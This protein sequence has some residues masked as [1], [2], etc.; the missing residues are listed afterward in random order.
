MKLIS[1]L[2]C[3][4]VACSVN[5]F[6]QSFIHTVESAARNK[7]STGDCSLDCISAATIPLMNSK[8]VQDH[9]SVH[10]HHPLTVCQW[11]TPGLVKD[12]C[13]MKSEANKCIQN[14]PN[15]KTKTLMNIA[16]EGFFMCD[17][18]FKNFP[19]L[20]PCINKTC[21]EVDYFCAAKCQRNRLSNADKLIQLLQEEGR[22]S[23]I[24]EQTPMVIYAETCSYLNC[25]DNCS[26][27]LQTDKCGKEAAE[28]ESA[29]ISRFI[30]STTN[31]I[32]AAY[33]DIFPIPE[34][35]KSIKNDFGSYYSG[36]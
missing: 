8:Y 25:Y 34:P 20:Y 35:C 30:S 11:Y 12:M 24:D 4:S 9:I 28:L 36:I 3:L 32:S 19:K 14:C 10:Q 22:L 18:Q 15:G 2:I 23:Q 7:R 27:P 29:I 17:E 1:L 5:C 33:G 6:T 26:K 31:L 21:E 16:L 13:V